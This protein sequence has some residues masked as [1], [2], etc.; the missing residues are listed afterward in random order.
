MTM[1]RSTSPLSARWLGAVVAIGITGCT[2]SA[3]SQQ[4]V[5]LKPGQDLAAAVDRAPEGTRFRLEPGVYRQ[6]TIRPKDRQEFVGQE[7]AILNGAMVLERWKDDAGVWRHE[8]LPEPL[9][10]RGECSDGR[11]LCGHREDLFVN[12]QLYQ[13]VEFLD[14]SGPGEMVLRRPH[15]LPGR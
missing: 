6:Q 10:F 2:P 5:V 3:Q 14:R 15:G 1:L 8:G 9:D 12:A 7:G 4:T 13:R 11:E